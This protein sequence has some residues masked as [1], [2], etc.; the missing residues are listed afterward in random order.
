M[1][2][3]PKLL[4][5]D[6]K[7]V[8]SLYVWYH[9]GYNIKL[10]GTNEVMRYGLVLAPDA[11]YISCI[12]QVSYWTHAMLYYA[13]Y[14]LH[15]YSTSY[16]IALSLIIIW[17]WYTSILTIYCPGLTQRGHNERNEKDYDG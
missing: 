2:I 8:I 12:T 3:L 13:L 10:K 14:Q 4:G 15:L 9:V 6:M 11:L 16:N 17:V 1:M 5:Y 7:T